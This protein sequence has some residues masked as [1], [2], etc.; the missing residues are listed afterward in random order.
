MAISIDPATKV[1]SIQQADLTLLSG[2]L[3][4][5]DTNAF[6]L[7]VLQLL[8]DE[9]RI[10]L[11]IAFSHNTEVTLGAE[12]FART[13]EVINGYSLTFENLVYSVQMAGSNNNFFDVDNN[14]LNPSGNVTVIGRNSAGLI[15]VVS[16][17][18]LSASQDTKLTDL[19]Q[20]RGLLSGTPKT[21]TENTVD[22]DYTETSS[23]MTKTIVKTGATT[24]V[25][26][27]V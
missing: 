8:D 12:T 2:T 11:P 27:T 16:G 14:I 19:H 20:D 24:V 1:I 17:S 4:E 7:S 22:E 18:G 13:I 23:G 6:R 21:I 25:T 10:F 3:Y 26:R 5:L 9:D 15:T